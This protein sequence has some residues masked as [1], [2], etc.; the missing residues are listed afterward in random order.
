MQFFPISSKCHWT[1]GPVKKKLYRENIHQTVGGKWRI[2]TLLS[3]KLTKKHAKKK[4]DHSSDVDKYFVIPSSVLQDMFGRSDVIG[5]DWTCI[6]AYELYCP[7]VG[8]PRGGGGVYLGG[9]YFH[10]WDIQRKFPISYF[11]QA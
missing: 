10:T 8:I 4:T 3:Q 9:G 11:G 7:Y 1:V 6:P 5:E 2:L